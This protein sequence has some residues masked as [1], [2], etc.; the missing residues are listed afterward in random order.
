MTK[1]IDDTQLTL[2]LKCILADMHLASAGADDLYQK[3]FADAIA[4]VE[5]YLKEG[6]T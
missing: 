3:A 1:L 5:S 4:I 6:N 2:T